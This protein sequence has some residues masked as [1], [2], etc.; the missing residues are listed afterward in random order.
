MH[1]IGYAPPG[2]R[3][4]E[5]ERDVPHRHLKDIQCEEISIQAPKNVSLSGILVRRSVPDG[6]EQ[7]PPDTIIVYLQ[8][9]FNI[10]LDYRRIPDFTPKAMLEIHFI[11]SLC[12]KNFFA[13]I[14]FTT[15]V[16]KST[17]IVS[18][19]LQLCLGLT[20]NQHRVPL[21]RKDSQ[22]TIFRS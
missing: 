11:V 4:Q 16:L 2:A 17:Q 3:S 7:Q 1:T 15:Q 22:K 18:Q 13:Q 10:H 21:P 20:G 19:W 12:F 6:V 8:G 14:N 9:M 5:I